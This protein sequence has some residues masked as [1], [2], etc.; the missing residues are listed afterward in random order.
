MRAADPPLSQAS[1]FLSTI[2]AAE[3]LLR[4]KVGVS[5]GDNHVGLPNGKAGYRHITQHLFHLAA[6]L[7]VYR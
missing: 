7:D 4:V 6:C 2:S 1:T 5:G 3:G